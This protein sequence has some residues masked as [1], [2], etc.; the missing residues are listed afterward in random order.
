VHRDVKPANVLLEATGTGLPILRLS[1]F[2]IAIRLDEPR[3]THLAQ[4]VHTPGYSAP[5]AAAGAEPDPRQDL[6]AVGVVMAEIA[7][8]E[9][10]ASDGTVPASGPLA[11]V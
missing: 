2:G 11:P 4:F 7:S 9:R 3:L 5:E 6:Y 8:G 10:P 1:D